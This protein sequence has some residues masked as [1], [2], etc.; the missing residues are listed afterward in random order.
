MAG[1]PDP[2]VERSRDLVGGS[3]DGD[4]GDDGAASEPGATAATGSDAAA[5]AAGG[6][7]VGAA[8]AD[9]AAAIDALREVDLATT[10]PIEALNLLA[11]VKD[12][13]EEP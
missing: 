4:D 8:D 10:T 5:G 3:D 2:V 12:R 13:L 1:V 11:T 9:V 7:A 6:G